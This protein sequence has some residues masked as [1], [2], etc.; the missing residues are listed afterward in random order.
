MQ[1]DRGFQYGGGT[2]T[3]QTR[4]A[5][6]I[7]H[8]ISSEKAYPH[9]GHGCG[10]RRRVCSTDQSHHQYG[11]GTPSVRISHTISTEKAHLQYGGGT[12][13]VRRRHTFSTEEGMQY[14]SATSSVQ[15]KACSV[16]L[17]KLFRGVSA[18]LFLWRNDFYRHPTVT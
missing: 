2:P 12:P 1:Y 13:S 10:V 16:G 4:C 7:I 14:R 5:V 3:V 9:Y 15:M 8:T 18:V 17:S 6:R 11:G